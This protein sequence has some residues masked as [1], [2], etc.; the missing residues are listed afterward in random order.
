M[1]INRV[2]Y[3]DKQDFWILKNQ[4]SA[5]EKVSDEEMKEFRHQRKIS[6]KKKLMLN[7]IGVC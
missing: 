2:T 6:K 5:I 4:R 3:R 7:I 1:P